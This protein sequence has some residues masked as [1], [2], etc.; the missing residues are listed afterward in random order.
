MK[1][2][3]PVTWGQRLFQ[4]AVV[5][6]IST[7]DASELKDKLEMMSDCGLVHHGFTNY[8]RDYEFIVYQSCDPNPKYG[9]SPRH[10]RFLFRFCP[11]VTI[12]S[13]LMPDVWSRSLS[14]DLLQEHMA[15]RDS[16]GYV[17]GVQTQELYP[18]A[19]VVE[20][21]PRAW[22]W[23]TSLGIDFHE[24]IVEANAQTI[25]LVFSA[26]LVDE[27]F[28]GYSPYQVRSQGI[29]EIYETSTKQPLRPTDS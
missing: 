29:P 18:G 16:A 26:I 20:E 4:T 17:W 3:T 21:S 25:S 13:R 5:G 15:T 22:F 24:I 14:D 28:D 11:E 6:I 7:V 2:C 9:L 27:V 12:T 19:T 1:G 10:L 23:T 8:I